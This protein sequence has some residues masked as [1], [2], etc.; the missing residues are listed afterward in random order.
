MYYQFPLPFEILEKDGWE[1]EYEEPTVPSGAAI[2]IAG[3]NPVTDNVFGFTAY[4]P[5]NYEIDMED[6]YITGIYIIEL[7]EEDVIK[8][9]DD[10]VFLKSEKDAFV[11]TFG[12]PD[13]AGSYDDVDYI[14]Y[15]KDDYTCYYSIDFTDGGVCDT[16]SMYN[17]ALP[18]GVEVDVEISA[19]APD[20]NLQYEAPEGPSE[21]VLDNIITVDGYNY[22]LPCPVSEFIN[23]GWTIGSETDEIIYGDSMVYGELEKNGEKFFCTI[24]NYTN[25][26]IYAYNGM[27]TEIEVE[28]GYL[29]D[30]EII[31]PG[32]IQLGDSID[33]FIE[34][35][36]DDPDFQ[37]H[38]DEDLCFHLEEV[39]HY[40]VKKDTNAEEGERL[41]IDAIAGYDDKIIFEYSYD[42]GFYIVY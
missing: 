3:Y 6:S 30:I 40:Y 9:A 2:D 4:N 24:T 8:F 31:F 16:V 1:L 39:H 23:N 21:D 29:Y 18:D 10:L 11:D 34:V 33:E 37:A 27:V 19:E 36:K 25:D 28:K 17:F 42:C 14:E 15:F 22:K 32:D 12:A 5:H 26:A 38:Q 35:Y 41:Y 7:C 13:Y 20:I